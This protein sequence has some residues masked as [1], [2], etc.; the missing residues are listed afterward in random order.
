MRKED[1]GHRSERDNTNRRS[2]GSAGTEK[3]KLTKSRRKQ[4]ERDEPRQSKT[5]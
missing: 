4:P 2:G 5:K 1:G 3:S